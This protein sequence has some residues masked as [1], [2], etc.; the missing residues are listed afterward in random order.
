MY[1]IYFGNFIF[2]DLSRVKGQKMTQKDNIS[3][4]IHYVISFVLHRIKIIIS[5]DFFSI[6]QKFSFFGLLEGSKGKK[7][8]KKTKKMSISLCISGTVLDMIVVFSA[9]VQS[10]DISKNFPKKG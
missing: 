2:G 8:Y 9:H 1:I 7:L 6:F 3:G 10:D 5:T 4:S